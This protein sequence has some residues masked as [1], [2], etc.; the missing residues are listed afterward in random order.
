MAKNKKPL[1]NEGTIRRMM[2]LAD[3]D[4]LGDGF[5]NEKW[6]SKA[7]E[8]KREEEGG[9]EKKAGDEEHQR[10]TLSGTGNEDL[11]GQ[12]VPEFV[13]DRSSHRDSRFERMAQLED[14]QN[15]RSG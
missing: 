9:V 5:I 4:A 11:Y 7:D 12:H 13:L 3:M 6:G 10:R 15:D 8:F 14:A 1:L 2:K